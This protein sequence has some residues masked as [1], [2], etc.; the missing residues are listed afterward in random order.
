[1][2]LPVR[3]ESMHEFNDGSVRALI[4]IPTER[5]WNVAELASVIKDRGYSFTNLYKTLDKGVFTI[6]MSPIKKMIPVEL[7]SLSDMKSIAKNI[8]ADANDAIWDLMDTA[9]GKVLIK[10][11]EGKASDLLASLKARGEVAS[12]VRKATLSEDTKVGDTVIVNINNREIA[13]FIIEGNKKLIDINGVELAF[14]E[15]N[16]VIADSFANSIF[17]SELSAKSGLDFLNKNKTLFNNSISEM[18]KLVGV[19]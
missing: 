1:M 9:S 10:R 17:A 11:H 18:S 13:G 12:S 7:A 14:C 8:F 6:F 5:K 2:S 4:A 15:H 19:I 16:V 3:L